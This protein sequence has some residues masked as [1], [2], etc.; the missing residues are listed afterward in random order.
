MKNMK[1]ITGLTALALVVI[2]A[3]LLSAASPVS[4]AGT[5]PTS[6]SPPENFAGSNDGGGA[7]TCTMSAPDDLRALIGQTDKE[8]GYGMKILAQ[9]DFKTDGG[10]GIIPRTGTTRLHLQNIR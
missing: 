8:R 6:I 7:V 10:H 9:V 4:A 3:L 5:P 1:R 2:L